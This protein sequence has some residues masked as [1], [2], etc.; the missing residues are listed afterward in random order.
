MTSKIKDF[1]YKNFFQAVLTLTA[2]LLV[3][4]LF[5]EHILGFGP[6]ILCVAQRIIYS[7]I[8]LAAL[9][10]IFSANVIKKLFKYIIIILSA[11]GVFVS[12]YQL[13]TVYFISNAGTNCIAP[14]SIWA[15]VIDSFGEL[16]P[17]LYTVNSSC[18]DPSPQVL[19][20]PLPFVSFLVF[21]FLLVF[22]L[23]KNTISG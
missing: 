13:C 14:D 8:L 6:C 5:T 4:T 2:V 1:M 3:L 21:V 17:L 12:G 11:I 9:A 20:I 23:Q 22:S 18:F 10:G 7:F 15:K 16:L 19:G